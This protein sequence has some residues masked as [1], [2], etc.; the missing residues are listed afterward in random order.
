MVDDEPSI[1]R[2]AQTI[3]Q[4][5]GYTVLLAKDGIEAL[6]VFSNQ[7]EK[8]SLVILDITMPHQ[9]GWEVLE[10]LRQ[11]DSSIKV[12]VSSGH[13]LTRRNSKIKELEGV[14]FIPKPYRPDELALK[15][16]EVLDQKG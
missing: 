13:R 15:V 2:L 16:R 1:R 11:I 7:R 8:I 4:K 3:L 6:K 12:I 10:D 9:T 14:A 5:Q